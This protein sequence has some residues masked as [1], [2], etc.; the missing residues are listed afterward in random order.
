MGLVNSWSFSRLADYERCPHTIWHIANKSPVPVEEEENRGTLIHRLAEEYLKG[1]LDRLPRELRRFEKEFIEARELVAQNLAITEDPWAF[2]EDWEP[3]D[4]FSPKAWLRVKTDLYIKVDDTS[5][6]IVDFKT[7]KSYNNTLKYIQQNILYQ[8]AA[9][10]K[11]P[12]LD[13][14]KTSHWFIDEGTKPSK[15]YARDAIFERQMERYLERAYT[16]LNDP[17]GTPKPNRSNCRFCRYGITNGS[18]T[19][20]Y[21]VA[22]D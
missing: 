17:T 12:H 8:I 11:Y 21:A 13:T 7:G 19:C 1:E 16:M 5:A 15:V 22:W 2:T 18:N 9:F 10:M 3:V 6:E 4:W 20:R 14:I